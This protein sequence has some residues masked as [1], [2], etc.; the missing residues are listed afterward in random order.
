MSIRPKVFDLLA[1]LVRHR[2]RVV[3]REELVDALWGS[4]VVCLGSLSGLVNELRSALGERGRGPSS[5]RTVHGRGYQFVAPVR[6]CDAVTGASPDLET[7]RPKRGRTPLPR[8][9][10]DELLA[11]V[12]S[13]P[14]RLDAVVSWLEASVGAA[15]E[16]GVSSAMRDVARAMRSVRPGAALRDGKANRG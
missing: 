10:A 4:T 7:T 11:H 9:L 15:R 3:L 14:G 8:A 16:A 2:E 1:Y 13:D 5:I 12:E 6:V